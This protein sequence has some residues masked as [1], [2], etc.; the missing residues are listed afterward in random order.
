MTDQGETQIPAM[1][2]A[3]VEMFMRRHLHDLRNHLYGLVMEVALLEDLVTDS[4]ASGSLARLQHEIAQ[5][6]MAMR[7]CA[8]RFTAPDPDVVPAVDLF[9]LW[10]SRCKALKPAPKVEWTCQANSETLRADANVVASALVELVACGKT[11][12]QKA[13]VFVDETSVC[14]EVRQTAALT[15]DNGLP[16]F[17]HCSKRRYL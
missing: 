9:T 5:M 17:D 7:S 12:Q 8:L 6:E 14:F 3:R 15:Q 13:S 4:E 16:E 2:A 1:D 10:R 11:V